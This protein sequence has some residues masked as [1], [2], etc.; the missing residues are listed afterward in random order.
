MPR[1]TAPQAALLIFA[2]AIVLALA[3][4]AQ[5]P[6]SADPGHGWTVTSPGGTVTATVDAHSGSYEL[7]VARGGRPMLAATLGGRPGPAAKPPVQDTLHDAFTTPTGKR[8][9]HVLD[10]RRLTLTFA[11]GRT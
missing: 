9:S 5:A 8:R 4:T 2:C 6:T 11:H 3:A 1:P 7:T 10:A